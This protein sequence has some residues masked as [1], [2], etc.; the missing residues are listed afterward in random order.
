MNYSKT[1]FGIEIEEVTQSKLE[2]FFLEEQQESDVFE[3][4]SF[5]VKGQNNFK[6]KE[7]G[8]LKTICG[9][10]NSSGGL[11]IWGAP[12]GTKKEGQ[13]EKIFIGELS[14]V[15]VKIEKDSFIAKIA[16]KIIPLPQ[17]V[18]FREIKIGKDKFVY[19]IEAQESNTKPHQ[20]DNRYFMRLDGQTNIAPHHYI[21][22]LFKKI[23]Y[24]NLGGYLK[25][26]NLQLN[27]DTI[28]LS[29]FLSFIVIIF[30][31]TPFQNEENVSIRVTSFDG[32]F[33]NYLNQK[34]NVKEEYH[35]DGFQA[36]YPDFIKISY[37]GMPTQHR[38]KVKLDVDR[39]RKNKNHFSFLLHFGE[40]KAP[41]KVSEYKLIFNGEA[42]E[43]ANSLILE[44]TENELMF[45]VGKG[46]LNEREKVEEFLKR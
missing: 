15:T 31:H 13:K 33:V 25:F 40:K 18:R 23:S 2:S 36:F 37:Y 11:L 6:E 26:E 8:I 38:F 27:K 3:L 46:T 10:L 32:K 1:I 19:L 22:A 17:G 21:D 35:Y 44:R 5:Y 42:T 20:F 29:F 41:I 7:K 12:I 14:P 4:K 34:P 45:D 28:F 43:D 24:P 39:I 16:N 30:N 9:F